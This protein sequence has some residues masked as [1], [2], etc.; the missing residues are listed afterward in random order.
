MQRPTTSSDLRDLKQ[1]VELCSLPVQ[2][3][4]RAVHTTRWTLPAGAQVWVANG[5]VCAVYA[6]KFLGL[7]S[8]IESLERW[9]GPQAAAL[10]SDSLE[11][12]LRRA[13]DVFDREIYCE[14]KD[15]KVKPRNAAAAAPSGAV[16][17]FTEHLK[18]YD[19]V[20]H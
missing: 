20:V 12:H 13:L 9:S 1:L 8:A 6:Q 3:L 2:Q 4:D 15:I 5:P 17:F 11:I 7:E 18:K 19:A 16:A 14:T 10:A